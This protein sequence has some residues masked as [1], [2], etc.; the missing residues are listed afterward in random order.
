[1]VLADEIYALG[2]VSFRPSWLSFEIFAV[3]SDRVVN[4]GPLTPCTGTIICFF[5]AAKTLGV[6]KNNQRKKT[7]RIGLAFGNRQIPERHVKS[8][9]LVLPF[10]LY[11]QGSQAIIYTA[12][13]IGPLGF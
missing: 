3:V 11:I 8:F 4:F 5:S 12:E 13:C 6:F 2:L 1:M 10:P 9:A 7:N